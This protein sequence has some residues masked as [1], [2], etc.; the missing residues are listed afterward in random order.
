M[1]LS[2]GLLQTMTAR[3]R[4]AKSNRDMGNQY[5]TSVVLLCKIYMT[6]LGYTLL[7]RELF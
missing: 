3:A 4:V 5:I 6:Q 2:N 1:K 7:C